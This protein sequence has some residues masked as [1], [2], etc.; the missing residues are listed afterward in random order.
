M[1]VA[2][3]AKTP[4]QVETPQPTTTPRVHSAI[5]AM[6]V[7]LMLTIVA[8]IVPFVTSAL[9][10]HI[11]TSYP[12]YTDAR[13]DSAVNTWLVVLTIIG[14]L[15]V[16]GWL[17]SIRIVTERK[18]WARWAATAM[19]V[20]GTCVAVIDLL[21]KDNSGDIGLAPMLGWI[22]MLPSLAG[23]VAVGLLWRPSS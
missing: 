15:G 2:Q 5:A 4:Q 11:R 22:G 16:I 1:Q 21:I 6:V 8:T 7:G 10:N 20:L 19:F 17:W 18:R 12:A 9:R 13:V 14:A 23:L 3:Q